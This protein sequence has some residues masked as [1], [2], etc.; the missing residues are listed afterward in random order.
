[1]G[2]ERAVA[3]DE[4]SLSLPNYSLWAIFVDS[5]SLW[6]EWEWAGVEQGDVGVL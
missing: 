3:H 4:A 1:M 2:R 5:H 6:W